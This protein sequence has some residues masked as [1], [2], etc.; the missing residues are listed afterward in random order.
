MSKYYEIDESGQY[1]VYVCDKYG[2]KYDINEVCC[3][4]ECDRL[5]DF[6]D[7]ETCAC[8]KLFTEEDGEV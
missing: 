6:V 3:N 7:S 8:C 2:C 5:G 4:E 1:K